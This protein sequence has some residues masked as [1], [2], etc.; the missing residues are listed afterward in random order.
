M[1]ALLKAGPACGVL[2]GTNGGTN[3]K[4]P[5]SMESPS[6]LVLN[7]NLLFVSGKGGV[8]KT[9]VSQTIALRLNQLGKRVL[10]ATFQ[11]PLMPSHE[12]QEIRPGLFHINCEPSKSF[13]EYAALKIG[14]AGI[15]R[16]FL[17]NKLM[18]YL[19]KAAPGI[20]EL[21]LLGKVWFERLNYDH[22]IVDMP[23]TGY[24]LAMFQSTRN[25]S[26]LF[27]GG[28][29]H[30]DTE[31]M[32][33]SFNNPRETGH[34]IVSLPEEMPLRESIELNGF[35]IGL[36]PDN[37]PSFLANRLFPAF[38]YKNQESD[39]DPDHWGSPVAKSGEDY[40]AKRNL[41]EKFN[42]KI[43]DDAG[44]QPFNLG[45]E[46]PQTDGSITVLVENLAKQFQTRGY[47]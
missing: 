35:L 4:M 39:P 38:T 32:L 8:G 47:L 23:S 11:D 21:V 17:Q 15:A 34:L 46:P 41:L 6:S 31:E 5:G 43:W 33:T 18:R 1:N 37:P 36:F 19:A 22:V 44:I 29:I 7:R 10:W 14:M 3:N 45:F 2:S 16:L 12:M 13:E 26:R 27:Q 28:P 25:F 40:A 24:G 9:V 42:L 20:H 30:R